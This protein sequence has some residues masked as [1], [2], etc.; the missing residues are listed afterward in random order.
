VVEDLVGLDLDIRG[1][2]LRAT[3]GLVDLWYGSYNMV[4]D[5]PEAKVRKGREGR[6][7]MEGVRTPARPALRRGGMEDDT[8]YDTRVSPALISRTQNRSQARYSIPL[9]KSKL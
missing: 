2:A 8:Q 7:G 1:L 3:Q 6:E 5:E 4:G 9:C